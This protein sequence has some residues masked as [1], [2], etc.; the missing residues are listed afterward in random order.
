MVVVKSTKTQSVIGMYT[1]ILFYSIRSEGLSTFAQ[2]A[3]HSSSDD[4]QTDIR[5]KVAEMSG[6]SGRR[7]CQ[8]RENTDLRTL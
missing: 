7:E 3:W 2:G 4:S 8:R 6:E 5:R 1:T